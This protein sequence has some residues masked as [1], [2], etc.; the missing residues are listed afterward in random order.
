[1]EMMHYMDIKSKKVT[2]YLSGIKI[3]KY[4]AWEQFA[5]KEVKDNRVIETKLLFKFNLIIGLTQII[6]ILSPI[7]ITMTI[8]LIYI[9]QGNELSAEKAFPVLMLVKIIE[10]TFL[11]YLFYL[12]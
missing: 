4:Y 12:M 1:M 10:V 5:Y 6:G 2:E 3:I 8:F 11:L 9:A 7:L